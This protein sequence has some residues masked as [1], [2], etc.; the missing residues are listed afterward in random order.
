[1]AGFVAQRHRITADG[2]FQIDALITLQA[3]FAVSR[4]PAANFTNQLENADAIAYGGKPMPVQRRRAV[5]GMSLHS[6]G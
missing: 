4:R 2:A 5:P 3:R 1:M 6:P